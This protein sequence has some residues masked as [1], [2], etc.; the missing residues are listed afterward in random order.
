[1][2]R[3][4]ELPLFPEA[5]SAKGPARPTL[6]I[7]GLQQQNE[8]L[9]PD[10]Q[11]F[12]MALIG[13]ESERQKIIQKIAEIETQL[14]GRSR[15]RSLVRGA[16]LDP[17]IAALPISRQAKYQ[18]QWKRDGRCVTCGKPQHP[19]SAQFCEGCRRKARIRNR[20][21]SRQKTNARVRYTGSASYRNP[22]PA[23]VL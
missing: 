6:S 2:I 12:Q 4:P 22:I 10:N 13:Y 1:M 17:D 9:M 15:K 16:S 21:R 23:P 3:S 5:K 20:D 14:E 19:E 7:A 18:R 11:L 8:D